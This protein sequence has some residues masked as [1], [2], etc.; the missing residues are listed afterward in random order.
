[1]AA[2]A[3]AAAAEN[4]KCEDLEKLESL[5]N[6][7]TLSL[8]GKR[9][10]FS[11]RGD[12]HVSLTNTIPELS[13]FTACVDLLFMGDSSS[14]WI[15]FSYITNNP[16]R[17][18]EDID[19]GLAGKHQQLLLY[20]L[21]KT[22]YISYHL[23]PFRWHTIC[24]RWDGVKGILELFLNKKR[25]LIVMDQP[26]N[27][28]PNGTLVLGHFPKNG[29]GQ[30]KSLV[31]RFTISLYH[32]QLWDHI[33]ENEEFMKCLSGN[34]VSWEEDVW[35]VNKIIPTID[36]RLR[37][38][39]SENMTIQEISTTLSQQ[40]ELT[41]PSQVTGLKPQK[42][43]YYSSVMSESMPV[44]A[45]D[46]ATM[47][48]SNTTLPP[49]ETITSK[50]LRTSIAKTATSTADISSSSAAM[51]LPTQSTS[52]C[53]A[54]DSM[55]ITKFTSSEIMRTTKIVE[56][57]ATKTFHPTTASNFLSA[58]GFTKNLIA[59]QTSA[60]E[61][62]SVIMKT[63]SSFST[64]ESTSMSTT[65][66]PKRTST[67]IKI[68]PSSTSGQEFLESIAA[69][70]V[71]W[72]TVGGNSGKSTGIRTTTAF[73]SKSS[74]SST[75][76]SID[77]VFPRNQTVATLATTDMKIPFTAHSVV[78]TETMPA[79][80]TAETELPST[81][82]Q[83]VS[84]PH[85]ED[86]IS[87]FMP[88]ETSSM[89]L[90]PV[91]SFPVTGTQRVQTGTN[92]E[93]S[94]ATLTLGITHAP[95]VTE[96]TS[97]PEIT[98]PV[99]T[100]NTPTAGDRMFTLISAISASTPKAFE[101]GPTS[102][103]D[104]TTHWFSSKETTWTSRPSRTL[105][106][107]TNTT[108]ILTFAAN[109]NDTS[110]FYGSTI[111]TENSSTTTNVIT[112][113]ESSMESK[114][115]TS[116]D[117]TGVRY[118]TTLSKLVSPW[119][120]NFSTTSGTVSVT[121]LPEFK[122]TTLLK[123]IPI[124]TV[125]A[126]ELPSTGETVVSPVDIASTLAD[127]KLNFSTEESSSEIIHTETDG[128]SAFGDTT[129]LVP[130]SATTQKSDDTMTTKEMT[131]HHLKGKSTIEAVS[132]VSLFSTVLEVTDESAQTVTASV[133][134]SPFLGG[135]KLT[136]SLDNKTATSELEGSSYNGITE[137]FNWTHTY[138]AHWTPVTP[139]GHLTLFPT[140]ESTQMFPELLHS[141]TT[142]ITGT[143][144]DRTAMSLS[145]S[146][147]PPKAAGTH[148]SATHI[149]ITHTFSLPV[150]FSPVTSMVMSGETKMT[151]PIT[152][153]AAMDFPT[154]LPSDVS[155]L[156]SAT[157]SSAMV[158][159]LS[160]TTSMTND[161][162]PTQTDS[163]HTT[164][165]A[166]VISTT[167]T[168]MEVPSQTETLVPLPRSPLPITTKTKATLPSTS[169]NA[170]TPST[171]TLVCSK[172]AA[173]NTPIVPSHLIS[174][175]STPVATQS[176][177]QVE[178]IST[179]ALNFPFTF[180]G[181]GDVAS[182]ATGPTETPTVTETIPPHTSA[183]KLT[184]SVDVRVSRPSTHFVNMPAST[185]SVTGI[186]ILPSDKDQIIISMGKTSRT[187]EVT[188]MSP[189]KYSFISNSQSTSSLEMTDTGF[190]ET[191]KMSSHQTYLPSEIPLETSADRN[192]TLSTTS[193]SI[194]TTPPLTSNSTVDVYFSEMSN[195]LGKTTLLSRPL[196][197]PT[198]LFPEKVSTN[199]LSIYTPGTV[200]MVVNSSS[201]THQDASF[202]DT[203]ISSTTRISNPELINITLPQF[204]SLNTQPEVTSVTF[205]I[206][207]NTQTFPKSLSPSTTALSNSD[208]TVTSTNGI[209]TTLSVPNVPIL[210]EETSMAM[211][212]PTSQMSSLPIDVTA[213][214]SKKVSDPFTIIM[215]KSSKTTYPACL[216]SPSIA[217]SRPVSETTALPVDDSTLSSATVSSDTSTTLESLSTS[218]SP[219]TPRTTVTTQASS[220]KVT[221]VTYPG[222]TSKSTA[223]SSA[224]TTSEMTEVSSKITPT[225]ISSPTEATFVSM[226][227]VPTTNMA[228][229]VTS[230]VDTTASSLLSSKNTE[231]LLSSTSD[232][233]HTSL[234][235]QVSPSWTNFRSMPGPTES[236][237]A[238]TTYL[239]SNTGKMIYLLENTSLTTTF[240]SA[241]SDDLVLYPSWTP[242]SETTPSLTSL[243][244]S[245]SGSEAEFSTPKS[246]PTSQV[247]GFPVV[248]TRITSSNTQSLLMTSWNTHR[249][250][251]SQFPLS[252]PAHNPTLN[253]METETIQLVPGSLSMLAASGTSLVS[254]DA[255]AASLSSTSGILP[256][257]GISESPSLST[258]LRA[259]PTSWHDIKHTFDKTTTFI[260]PGSTVPPSPSLISKTTTSPILTW[261]LSSLP[262]GSS[263]MTVSKV[264]H[265]V[266]SSMVEAS[267]STLPASDMA[268][269]TFTNFTKLPFATG[270]TVLTKITS[271]PTL[272][273]TTSGSP[274]SLPM[275]TRVTDIRMHSLTSPE[276][277]SRTIMTDNSRTAFKPPSFS[278]MSV[279]P[280][281]TN[282]TVSFGSMPLP[283]ATKISAWSKT[284]ATSSPTSLILPKS[285]LDSL[286]N[287]TTATSTPT[288][289]SSSFMSTGVAH[290]STDVVSSLI[291][292]SFETTWLDSAFS[293]LTTE[294]MTSPIA[295]ESI[296]SFYN[297]EMT[298]SVFDEESRVLIT[299][300][301][302]EFAKDWLSFIFEDSEFCLANLA[303]QIKGRGT[304]E[305]EMALYWSILEQR[306]GQAMATISHVPYSCACQAIIKATSSL[307]PMELINKIRN[308]IYGNL[309]HGNFIQ[310]DL[311]LLVKS[312]HIVMK[313]LDPGMCKPAETP[314][315]Y[316]G[317]YKWLLTNPTETAQTRCIKNEDGNATRI[318]SISIETGKSQW[319][320]PRFKQCKLLQKLPDKIVD[321]ANITIND[322]N[323]DDVAEHI[324]K[325]IN[326]S[327]PLDEEETR[328]IVSKVD[329]ISKCDEISMNI[330]QIMLQI[331][332]AVLEKQNDSTS[333]LHQVSNTILRII[334]RAGHKMEFS[335]R[336]ANITVSRLALAVLRARSF[337]GMAFS[338]H[339]CEDGTSPEIYLGAVPPGRVL[340]SI[341][342]PKSLREKIPLNNLQT[343]LFNF[344]GQT[345]LFKTKDGTKTL[346]SYVVSASI[347]DM[348]IQNL[349]DPVVITLQH[350][351]GN[352]NYHQ[353]HCAFWDFE[354][355]NG[356]GGWN[357][358]GCKVKKTTVNYTICLCDHLTHFGVLMDLARSA[359]DPVNEQILV[360][361]TYTGCGISSIFLGIAMVTYI[362]FYKLR[363]DY[364]SK[365]LINLCTA[366]L[367]LNLAFLINSWFS[368]FQNVS[369]CVTAAVA[370]H[371]FLLVSLTWM[372]LEAV[373]MYFALVKVFNIYITNYILKFCLVGWG[374]PAITVAVIL[375][376]RKDIYGTLSPTTLF[377]WIKDDSTFYA[378]VV[379][380]FCL[381]FFVNL[382]MFCTVL[383]QLNSMKSQRQKTRRKM[384]LR[385]LKGTLSLTFL[386][387]L[388]WGFAFF[389]W[390]PVRIF[391][392]Y[393]FAIC[394][395]L[396]GFLIFVF[397][398]VMKDSVREQW[399]LHLPC[400]W[401]C[402]GNFSDGSSKPG[403]NVGYKKERMKKT[404]EHKLLT[405]S[406][407]STATSSTFKSL[408]SVKDTPSEISFS[409]G[410]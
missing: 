202:V 231:T 357:S 330:T 235:I 325:L 64:S 200:E 302:H 144:T 117:A 409:N 134:V 318:C 94:H 145:S 224:F 83:N 238:T 183:N 352:L 351:E 250:E 407:K 33:L 334:E 280:S 78:P 166:I 42:T 214:T 232:N 181:N 32:F 80:I 222:M 246:S 210:L 304:S 97:S 62:Q 125:A 9:L 277:T 169:G 355:N 253:K 272:G 177:S 386:L 239:S 244:Y 391:F 340:T 372:G 366:L 118:T 180:S 234:N 123:T 54:T 164:S 90:S 384:I 154:S 368:S 40:I 404:F 396:Q 99:N 167:M 385:D 312:D 305:E 323:A 213:F 301:I 132:E 383:A 343:I 17:G 113:P 255:L 195:S 278:G 225:S 88:Q 286:I 184:A 230:V 348:S 174:T 294:A 21:G 139:K 314:S 198:L 297:I 11:G 53:N 2:A 362:A 345:S 124:P 252:T 196:T 289:T 47:L 23:I 369:L 395:T 190:S 45:T 347:S 189:S 152:S 209:S 216:K 56:A 361:I 337:E 111:N 399:R 66:W 296:V 215:I 203:T 313:K 69:V 114:A 322:E 105:L 236:I 91:T 367:M 220:L 49:S 146:I 38:F 306:E 192:S 285:I 204:S 344:F 193:K 110:A 370:L 155:N 30:I 71:P 227:P 359:V 15:A 282:R 335:G 77:S 358:S 381:I 256:T 50:I 186:S 127:I 108:T 163:I 287:V 116:A 58:S 59:P 376:V 201:V 228:G 81:N 92:A 29:V 31:P 378:S 12:T 360:V 315:N 86:A 46:Y 27:L 149:P 101:S 377:C 281:I 136:T 126:N 292:L 264:P 363:K 319:E 254:T 106:T 206:S 382:S 1:M 299:S 70:T 320:K 279:S 119:L 260:T 288:G 84:S 356:L 237:K 161:I 41:T 205:S 121:D 388:T 95:P 217:T 274:T 380:Y 151:M 241:T 375:S 291:S 172:P 43:I 141:S 5:C 242:S 245:S 22:F 61:S 338:I 14:Y 52:I 276:T 353:L 223:V 171:H 93:S 199:A 51:T 226:I 332:S 178:E 109:K 207:E 82:F 85:V 390:G 354:T 258:S 138:T 251:D 28:T 247:V 329:E 298:L 401:L 324:L 100:Q 104:E 365:I 6:A 307:E 44:F 168:P 122:L 173:D 221:P 26:H 394:N 389:A 392:L 284:P 34:V 349:A 107:S 405:P 194:W 240:R 98:E 182:L 374:L 229:A 309:T 24:L 13:R 120:A 311:I 75:A 270:R 219:T 159:P 326:E 333:N 398:C 400:G 336:T 185:Q 162:M 19:L 339:S 208:F 35:L 328:I 87:T 346:T 271:I 89:A 129:A 379:A 176:V 179:S 36:K 310:D 387:G 137:F 115:I 218:L 143:P 160:Q 55:K 48:Y 341:Y 273:S 175:V 403:A 4:I 153:K 68:P 130:K 150:T 128:T 303:V 142:R 316:K 170:V 39:V 25:I 265:A 65:S 364:P 212:I 290:S 243:L 261:I 293:F 37:C 187:M 76:A 188:E 8:K 157:M 262:P 191:R 266:A 148:P 133:T 267:K 321:F 158:P 268:T 211:S 79:L 72:S 373:H 103:T 16:F 165:E 248:G 147:L 408:G 233:H 20:Y 350:T 283:S 317:T 275:S 67:D 63:A 308:K 135:E 3:S 74:L 259:L 371:Y 263:Q 131:S 60:T 96:T 393:L 156:S 57:M 102:L 300:I 7:N 327:P 10:D 18:R 73:T 257:L 331:I 112:P 406:L 402:L 342:L 140:P 397:Y 249:A 410:R 197:K 269:Y 295:S